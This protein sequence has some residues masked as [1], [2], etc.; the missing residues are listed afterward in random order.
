MDAKTIMAGSAL[1]LAS[2][3]TIK[4]VVT[5]KKTT[6]LTVKAGAT[7]LDETVAELAQATGKDVAEIPCV[8]MREGDESGIIHTWV[9]NGVR[10]PDKL[11]KKIKK[12]VSKDATEVRLRPKQ[13]GEDVVYDIYYREGE[14][15]SK[16]P[17][18]AA[19]P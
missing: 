16:D 15:P 4:E 7:E 19:E 3:L 18:K 14:K 11:Q 2:G 1:L 9:C 17:V 12:A 10:V 8:L 5:D 13:V 6:E